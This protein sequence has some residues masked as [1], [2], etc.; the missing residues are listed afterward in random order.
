MANGK[1]IMRKNSFI[2]SLLVV[3]TEIIKENGQVMYNIST[4]Y[5]IKLL[6]KLFITK[7]LMEI[8]IFFGNEIIEHLKH[9]KI[10]QKING[11]VYYKQN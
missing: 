8:I 10:R 6:K 2:R 7:Q 3:I 5:W 1:K 4:I 9:I 11:Y